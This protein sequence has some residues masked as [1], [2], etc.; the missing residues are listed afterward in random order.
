MLTEKPQA[1]AKPMPAAW[2]AFA[3]RPGRGTAGKTDGP[4]A[5]QKFTVAVIP[6]CGWPIL[7]QQG[8]VEATG[9]AV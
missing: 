7:G 3:F 9:D 5:G 6:Y 1:W 4:D 8:T 2:F